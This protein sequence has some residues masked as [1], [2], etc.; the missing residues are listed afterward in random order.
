M[1]N[2]SPVAGL[3]PYYQQEGITL[4][5]GDCREILPL[6]PSADLLLTDPPYSVGRDQNECRASGNI[7]VALH[8]ASEK[9]D[10]ALVFSGSSNR[11]VIFV[12]SS[13]RSLPHNR[14]LCWHNRCS[15]SVATGPWKW[16]L[17]L[18]HYFGKATPYQANQPGA[19]ISSDVADY[20]ESKATGHRA[21]IPVSVMEHFYAPFAPC[22]VLDPFCGSGSSLLAVQ[23]RGGQAIGI[24]IEERYC[25]MAAQR[26]SAVHAETLS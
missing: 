21:A 16:D 15:R 26:L 9:V 17:I 14:I 1:S 22:S 23:R 19:V 2:P 5:Q 24:D 25:E 20:R 12:T 10:R 6:L 3:K 13:I 18:V 11:S 7:A 8:L 4:Y